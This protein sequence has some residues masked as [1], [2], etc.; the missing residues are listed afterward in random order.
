MNICVDASFCGALVLSE[1]LTQSADRLMRQWAKAGATLIAPDLWAY[2]VTAIV[3]KQVRTG[4]LS[5]GESKSAL[6]RFFILPIL[7]MRPPHLHEAA[8]ALANKY[9]LPGTYDAHYL[10]LAQAEGADLWTGDERLYDQVRASL[11]WVRWLGEA[12]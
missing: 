5:P 6:D 1:P 9:G 3:R 8:L 10:A 2:E 11:P 7:L 12:L 4:R